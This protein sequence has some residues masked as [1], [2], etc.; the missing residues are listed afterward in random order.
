[1]HGN[2]DA[3]ECKFVCPIVD[4]NVMSVWSVNEITT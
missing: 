4:P 2:T 3:D 1:M